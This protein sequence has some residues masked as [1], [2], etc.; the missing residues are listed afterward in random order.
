MTI[1]WSFLRSSVS[2]QI[3]E[4][5]GMHMINYLPKWIFQGWLS[6]ESFYTLLIVVKFITRCLHGIPA[7]SL[8]VIVTHTTPSRWVY[9]G[10]RCRILYPRRLRVRGP[11]AVMILYRVS[12]SDVSTFTSHG[13]YQNDNLIHTRRLNISTMYT[14]WVQYNT[15]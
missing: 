8:A 4:S 3:Y 12:N 2:T 11:I 10:Y 13:L 6:G 5:V 1:E 7:L 9:R 14:L 15:V